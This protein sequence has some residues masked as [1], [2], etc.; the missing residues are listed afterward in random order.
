ML[1]I[2]AIARTDFYALGE[3]LKSLRLP[4]L[5]IKLLKLSPI[6]VASFLIFVLAQGEMKVGDTKMTVVKYDFSPC[7]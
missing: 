7:L 2:Y 6:A 5:R 1:A 4:K 3:D